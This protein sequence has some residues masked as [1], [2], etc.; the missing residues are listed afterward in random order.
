MGSKTKIFESTSADAA[1]IGKAVSAL[2]MLVWISGCTLKSQNGLQKIRISLPS[3]HQR[4]AMVSSSQPRIRSLGAPPVGLSDFTCYGVKVTG[5]DIVDDSRMG[6]SP[7][8]GIGII[9]GLI[10]TTGGSVDLMV[11]AG[12]ARKI[13]VFGVKSSEGCSD[14]GSILSRPA[15]SRFDQLGSFYDLGTTTVD[16]MN[17][18]SVTVQIA[19]TA[20]SAEVFAGCPGHSVGT[21]SSAAVTSFVG[22]KASMSGGSGANA[23]N[24][25]MVIGSPVYFPVPVGGVSGGTGSYQV[26][27]MD[28]V[29]SE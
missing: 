3:G 24:A 10:P 17:D 27:W 2:L 16:I 29:Q 25:K 22:G 19:Y 13:T 15:G 28:G 9:G 23:V 14:F 6:C 18:T 1:W 21:V 8:G 11:P 26:R 5:S 12:P 4:E 7:V 20:Q